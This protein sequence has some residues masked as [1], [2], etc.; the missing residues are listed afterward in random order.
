[1]RERERVFRVFISGVTK[2]RKPW[3]ANPI[4]ER[5]Y[6]LARDFFFLVVCVM[7]LMS[8]RTRGGTNATFVGDCSV[9]ANQTIGISV[10]FKDRHLLL[11]FLYRQ[12]FNEL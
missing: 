7:L 6:T 1:M 3:P 2:E 11:L 9:S 4:R 12:F 8:N 10:V 5:F